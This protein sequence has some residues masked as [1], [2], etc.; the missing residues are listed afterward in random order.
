MAL[1]ASSQPVLPGPSTTAVQRVADGTAPPTGTV[2][3][4]AREGVRGP[5][6]ALPHMDRIQQ[7]FGRHDVGGVQA[8]VGGAA[9][10]ASRQMGAQAYAAGDRVAFGSS[11]DLH[12]AAH[13]AAHVVQQRGGV[14]L[15][16]GVGAAGDRYERHADAVAD[17]VVR[18]EPA[19]DLLDQMSGGPAG[20]GSG[21]PAVQRAPQEVKPVDIDPST[22]IAVKAGGDA[23][24]VPSGSG[25]SI[26]NGT[27]TWLLEVGPRR[28]CHFHAEYKPAAVSAACPTV[29]F[30]Q[31]VIYKAELAKLKAR[32]APEPDPTK[33]KIPRPQAV[34]DPALKVQPL[35]PPK[36]FLDSTDTGTP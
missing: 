26:K 31:T 1:S 34:D 32:A 13:E 28:D 7:L 18:G 5:G 9:A 23:K 15:E 36:S 25:A 14:Q 24:R 2:H 16:G 33:D 29:T 3:A 17:Q 27:L 35:D 12:T 8:H 10:D 4:A 20:A 6:S 11:P 19:E 30:E 21:A 22:P